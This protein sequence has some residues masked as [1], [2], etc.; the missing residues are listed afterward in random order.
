MTVGKE[1][2]PHSSNCHKRKDKIYHTVQTVIKRETKY[3]TPFEL[4]SNGKTK[5]TTPFE[6]SLNEKH[7]IAYQNKNHTFN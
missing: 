4:S 5:Y 6:L 2:I 3:I 7:I 1:N